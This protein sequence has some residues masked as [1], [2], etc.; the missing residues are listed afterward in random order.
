MNAERHDEEGFHYLDG[1]ARLAEKNGCYN[2]YITDTKIESRES[3]LGRMSPLRDAGRSRKTNLTQH[4]W[5][6]AKCEAL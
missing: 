3:L 2:Y 5:K 6:K 1:N 4:A